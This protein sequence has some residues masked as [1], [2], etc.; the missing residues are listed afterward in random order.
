V[1]ELIA[2]ERGVAPATVGY[3]RIRPPLR[4]ITIGELANS[5]TE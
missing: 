4:P 2:R 1:T 5:A 3:Y